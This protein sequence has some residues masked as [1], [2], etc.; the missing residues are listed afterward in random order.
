MYLPRKYGVRMSTT[1]TIRIPE[2]LKKRMSRIKGVNW[3]EV[4]RRAILDKVK[5]EEKLRDK[6]W[7]LVTEAV[8][9]ADK[10]RMSLETRHGKCDYDSAETIRY[11]R[12]RRREDIKTLP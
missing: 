4:V 3:S 11:W 10:L 9:Q 8:Q 1:I 6:N 5:V 2:D 12:N 7:N